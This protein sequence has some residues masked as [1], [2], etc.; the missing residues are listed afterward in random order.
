M[1]PN[2]AFSQYGNW[3]ANCPCYA[4]SYD[5]Y[6]N[7][8]TEYYNYRQQSVRGQA[9]WTTGGTITKCGI[10]WTDNQSMTVAVG[11]GSPYQC[12]QTLKVRNLS[13]P[14][15]EV[16]VE[17]VDTVPGY[18]AN[19]INL[20]K[21]A[22]EALGANPDQGVINIE[23][24]PSPQL[25][26]EKWGKYLLEITQT[27]YPGYNVTEYNTIGKTQLTPTETKETYEFILQSPQERIKIRGNVIYNTNTERIIS[28]DINEVNE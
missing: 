4:N 24:I 15:R 11:E 12:G 9:T 10:P 14:G 7:Y 27:A 20:Q 1:Y 3:Y 18:P 8:A 22:F 21:K 23:I 16:L 6:R 26:L 25:E 13:M 2:Y 17:V 5:Y 19:R 28:F